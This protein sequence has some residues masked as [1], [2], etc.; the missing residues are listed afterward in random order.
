MTKPII[1]SGVQP[2]GIL[3]I[4]NYFGAL[5]QWLMLQQ[6]TQSYY[7]IVDLH[8]ITVRQDPIALRHACLDTMALYLAV[9]IDPQQSTVF[10]QSHVPAHSQ[11][12]WILNCYTQIGE[13]NRMTQFKEKSS[14]YTHNINAGL[15]D[16]P[17]LMAADI[18]LYQTDL[19]PVGEDQT[20][21]LELARDIAIRFNNLYGSVF[22]VPQVYLPQSCAR[23]MSL[24][25]PMKKMSKSDT[26][27]NAWIGL[28]DDV[29]NITK[30]IKSA[31]TDSDDPPRIL[32]DRQH[33]PGIAN[34][35]EMFS[36]LTQKSIDELVMA[37]DG[38]MYGHLKNDLAQALI[39]EIEPIQ[40]RYHQIRQ[41]QTYLS[42][43]MS[44]GREKAC[45]H[46]QETLQKVY[47]CIGFV[48]K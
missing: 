20:Q 16:Y 47:D 10:F 19:V 32:F 30:K 36:V 3:T 28:L 17:V 38:K 11:L 2:S 33:K 37:Y 1:F 31:V 25:D 27:P 18:L 14:Q 22:K 13:L 12:A 41:D 48:I 24:Q 5:R 34:L 44:S 42:E 9:G 7:C 8:A 46:A 40:A 45:A 35:L 4:G 6:T 23:V 21:H 43:L 26:N 39:A 29:K 15:F